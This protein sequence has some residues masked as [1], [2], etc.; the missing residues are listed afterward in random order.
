MSE[1]HIEIVRNELSSGIN[2]LSQ[3]ITALKDSLLS[4]S[5][6]TAG[7]KHETGRASIQLEIEQISN[8]LKLKEEMFN[9]LTRIKFDSSSD[10]IQAGSFVKSSIG[11]FILSVAVGKISKNE[12]FAVSLSSPFAKLAIG[13]KVGDSFELNG[14]EV[15]IFE[16]A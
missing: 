6:S 13:L 1:I 12:A 2:H 14:R 5:K 4:E 3:Q 16:V 10:S 15:E 9:E 8:Q 7:D 11:T